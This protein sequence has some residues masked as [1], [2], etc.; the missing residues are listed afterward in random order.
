MTRQQIVD[1][2]YEAIL[3]LNRL[4][5]KYGIISR[6]MAEVGEQ[7]TNAA[8]AMTHHINELLAR[9]GYDELPRLKTRIDEI[10]ASPV[11]ERLQL[12][13]PVGLVKLKFLPSLWSW[14]TRR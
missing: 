1:T 2:A 9:G 13:L 10:N 14:A 5:A 6:Q 4:K 3:R 11:V 7:R 12:E 8:W